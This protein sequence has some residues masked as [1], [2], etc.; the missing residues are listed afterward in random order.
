MLDAPE[1]SRQPVVGVGGAQEEQ[2]G[3]RV[4]EPVHIRLY[5]ATDGGAG[6]ELRG[7][8]SQPCSCHCFKTHQIGL[9]FVL[10]CRAA[11]VPEKWTRT[12]KWDSR[13]SISVDFVCVCTLFGLHF[14]HKTTVAGDA[15]RCRRSRRSSSCRG[16]ALS[17]LMFWDTSARSL[18][19]F[20][21]RRS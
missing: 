10:L 4:V 2:E 19:V 1:E 21:C 18:C 3:R 12:G 7:R 14:F 17:L 9:L 15:A 16:Q 20:L 8:E 5:C 6:G 13:R 11:D